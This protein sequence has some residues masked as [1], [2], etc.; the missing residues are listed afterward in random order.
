M[1]ED[2]MKQEKIGV[3]FLMISFF[4][5]IYSKSAVTY[6]LSDGRFGDQ[7]LAYCHAKWISHS[8]D[9]PLLYKPFK[10]SDELILHVCEEHYDETKNYFSDQMLI[11]NGVAI[12]PEADILYIVP[13]FPESPL[14]ICLAP[15]DRYYFEVGWNDSG[16][17]K[18]IIKMIYPINKTMEGVDL[19][20]Q[21]ISIGIHVRKGTHFDSILGT[22]VKDLADYNKG[23]LL[24][25]IPPD[26]YYI[27]QIITIAQENY[28]RPLY[29]YI[30]TDHDNPEQIAMYYADCLKEYPVIFDYRKNEN[31]NDL[32]V[33]EDFFSMAFTVFD[34]LIRPE[35]HYSF[36]ASKIGNC[37]KII[38]PK[39][40]FFY[41][42]HAI[43]HEVN[44][45]IKL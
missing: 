28:D 8:Y 37:K 26:S 21:F 42:N 18:E 44:R 34:Y 39:H 2:Q 38:S 22:D 30:F 15:F 11:E 25:K 33:L 16:Y 32:N 6:V 9:I 13:F 17:R 5:S 4:L 31:R 41:N 7:L 23:P 3:F 19:P 43:I 45:E 35:S 10:Y 36:V 24:F 1:K 12:D 40:Y 27:D 14:E 20:D 29:V